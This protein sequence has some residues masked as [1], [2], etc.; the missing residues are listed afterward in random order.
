MS[1]RTIT[2]TVRRPVKI[3]DDAWPKI[4]S[5]ADGDHDNQY[6]CQ[7]NRTW[8]WWINVRRH[9]DGRAIVYAGYDYSTVFQGEADDHHREGELLDADCTDADICEVVQRVANSMRGEPENGGWGR[10]AAEC[11]AD[12]PAEV[13]E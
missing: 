2:L 12:M 7:A 3:D 1:K 8:K 6:E 4:A 10:L 5:A 11:I 9:A 13:L